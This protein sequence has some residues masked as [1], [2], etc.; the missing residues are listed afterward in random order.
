MIGGQAGM[1]GGQAGMVKWR[2]KFGKLTLGVKASYQ[3]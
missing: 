1:I 3:A 2:V